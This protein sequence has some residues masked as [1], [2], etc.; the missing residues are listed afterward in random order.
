MPPTAGMGIGIDRLTMFLTNKSSIQEVLFFP[1]MRPERTK[2]VPTP[3]DF[4]K[5][6]VPD[7]WAA[8]ALD[9]YGSVEEMR[10]AKDTQIHQKLNGLR[11]KKKLDIP[12]L[13]LEDVQGWIQA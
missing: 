12:A 8:A 2:S 5:A 13:S 11:K 6:G 4:V 10:K 1:Q 7:L 3:A 9:A